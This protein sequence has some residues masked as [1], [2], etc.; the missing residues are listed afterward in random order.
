[1][2]VDIETDSDFGDLFSDLDGPT[3]SETPYVSKWDR[4]DGLADDT[5]TDETVTETSTDEPV[6]TETSTGIKLNETV[7]GTRLGIVG[8]EVIAIHTDPDHGIECMTIDT[9]RY[10]FQTA[11]L[12]VYR[13]VRH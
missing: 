8:G 6:V 9:G 10:T 11:T 13:A 5:S 4:I 12:E 2:D 1:M 3:E 7:E